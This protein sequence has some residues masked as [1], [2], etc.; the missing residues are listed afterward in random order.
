MAAKCAQRSSNNLMAVGLSGTNKVKIL[1]DKKVSGEI[2]FQATPFSLD[3]Y[4]LNKK[5]FLIVGGEEG[6]IYCF[7]LDFH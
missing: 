2:Q 4:E 3:F 7:K 1:K 6:T 5:D